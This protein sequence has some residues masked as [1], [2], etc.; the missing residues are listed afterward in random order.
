MQAETVIGNRCSV[1][2]V[3]RLVWCAPGVLRCAL[4]IGAGVWL[5][6]QAAGAPMWWC[7][8]ALVLALR[9]H[10][11]CVAIGW[12]MGAL[13]AP[14]LAATFEARGAAR[15]LGDPA[16]WRALLKKPFICYLDLQRAQT[17]GRCVVGAW[18]ALGASAVCAVACMVLKKLFLRSKT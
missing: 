15:L 12:G 10:V 14:H 4:S 2:S 11:P 8:L 7:G 16:G 5:G 18:W 13:L 3:R 1:F 6:M 17:L 9:T